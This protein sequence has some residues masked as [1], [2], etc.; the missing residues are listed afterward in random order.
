MPEWTKCDYILQNERPDLHFKAIVLSMIDQ[1]SPKILEYIMNKCQILQ[2]NNC[3]FADTMLK[4]TKF[5]KIYDLEVMHVV[6]TDIDV[7]F[8]QN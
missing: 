1:D 5:D 3:R 4:S 8:I 7:T 6:S 2:I